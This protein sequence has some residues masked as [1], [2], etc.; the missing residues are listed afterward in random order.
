VAISEPE[1]RISSAG[2]IIAAMIAGEAAH[3]YAARVS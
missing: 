3:G 2:V 1:A